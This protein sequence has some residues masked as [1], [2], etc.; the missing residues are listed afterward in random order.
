MSIVNTVTYNGLT[1]VPVP[2][3]PI[4][5][6]QLDFSGA[7]LTKFTFKPVEPPP[8]NTPDNLYAEIKV[9][10]QAMARIYNGG[11]VEMLNGAQAPDLAQQ[12][13][14]PELA[15]TRAQQVADALK[16][17]IVKADTAQTQDKWVSVHALRHYIAD[18]TVVQNAL[19][20][21]DAQGSAPA[22]P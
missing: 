1:A 3:E 11:T 5:V 2:Q 19:D 14:G 16:G 17:T 8:D 21:L 12:G 22:K 6:R 15:Q 7:T 10:D 18:V 20:L 9:D 4:T 13:T